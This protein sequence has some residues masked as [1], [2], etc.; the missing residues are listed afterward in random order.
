[1][2]INIARNAL[3]IFELNNCKGAYVM[4]NKYR[5]IKSHR[6]YE[7]NHSFET[8]E[9]H[10]TEINDSLKI[11]KN[12]AICHQRGGYMLVHLRYYFSFLQF[13]FIVYSYQLR[14]LKTGD[15]LTYKLLR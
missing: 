7:N 13:R 1:M 9:F 11:F 5:I 2:F 4:P 8:G 15:T 14:D 3:K 10:D 6:I 12:M